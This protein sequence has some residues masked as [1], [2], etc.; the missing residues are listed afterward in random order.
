[1]DIGL[2]NY[3][4]TAHKKRKELGVECIE[5]D[6]EVAECKELEEEEQNVEDEKF[7]VEE[8]DE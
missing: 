3:I 4:V 2:Q 8:E 7:E 1:M 5:E 6:G